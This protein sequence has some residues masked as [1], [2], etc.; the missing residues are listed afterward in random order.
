MRNGG[1]PRHQIDLLTDRVDELEAE[2]RL[3][4]HAIQA[5]GGARI[6]ELEKSYK[7]QVAIAN[8]ESEHNAEL[9]EEVDKLRSELALKDKSIQ[10]LAE[11]Y[12][13]CLSNHGV[14]IPPSQLI[15]TATAKAKEDL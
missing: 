5:V 2:N 11:K 3:L 1:K 15:S 10:V 13:R 7:A 6:A 8:Q 12:S 4:N 14:N 9:A